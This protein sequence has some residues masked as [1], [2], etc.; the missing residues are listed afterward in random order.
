MTQLA[1]GGTRPA[2]P[3]LDLKAAK[4]VGLQITFEAQ[5]VPIAAG[6]IAWAAVDL[7][8]S[9]NGVGA[10]MTLRIPIEW[11]SSTSEAARRADVLQK[12]RELLDHACNAPA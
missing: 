9:A 8:Y 2:S 3:V 10:E 6:E 12:A 4:L 5:P 11:D 1:K 7:V